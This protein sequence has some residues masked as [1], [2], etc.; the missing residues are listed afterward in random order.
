MTS[1]LSLTFDAV[2]EAEPGAK[3]RARWHRSWPAYEAWFTAR[4]GDGGPDRAA[5]EAALAAHMPELVPVHR[6]LTGL[7]GGGDRAARFLSTW[8]PPAYLGGCSIAARSAG[9]AVRLV[10]NY[11]LSP[12]LNEGLLLRSAWTGRPVMGMAEFLWGLSD[13]V[14][15]RGFA[16]ALAYGG[17]SETASGFGITTILRYLLETCATTREALA[18]LRRV[19]SHMAYNVV[20]ADASGRTASVELRP[21]G[22]AHVLEPSIATNHQHGAALPERPAF[23]RTHARRAHLEALLRA[24]TAPAELARAFLRPPLFQTAHAACF[25]TLFTADYDPVE[26]ALALCWPGAT[27][28]QRLD[29]FREGRRVVRYGSRPRK[30]GIV[31]EGGRSRVGRSG[32]LAG[33]AAVREHLGLPARHSFDA[34]MREA[35]GGAPDWPALGALF[36]AEDAAVA[37]AGGGGGEVRP[38]SSGA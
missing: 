4:G 1:D 9:G 34:W 20:L 10:R 25:G 35:E 26:G 8:C 17:N 5:C 12:D 30:P 6:R 32:P 29:E 31:L 24:R 33:L 19:P 23:T 28:H 2:D 13:G 38:P 27:W 14:N 37:G 15:D 7:A 3:W 21:G 36:A 16:V 18:V 11:D 22:G